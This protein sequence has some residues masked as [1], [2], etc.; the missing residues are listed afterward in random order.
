MRNARWHVAAAALVLTGCAGGTTKPEPEPPASVPAATAPASASAASCVTS[1]SPATLAER[2]FAFDGTIREV[3][4][5]TDPRG[6]AHDPI[7]TRA[8]FDVHAWYAG[9]HLDTV[10][11]W[12]QRSAAKGDRL[13]VAGEPR[14][15]GEPLDDPIAWECGFTTEY[16]LERARTWADAHKR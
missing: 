13:L 2:A 10:Q 9:G 16:S 11:V 7:T 5:A 12:L 15:G 1:Y 8:T 14:W 4:Q 3:E 6:P